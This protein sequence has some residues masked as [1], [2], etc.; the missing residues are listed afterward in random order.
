VIIIDEVLSRLRG[1]RSMGGYWMAC[2][3][4]HPDSKASLSIRASDNGK[5]LFKCFA[6]CPFDAINA[7]LGGPLFT[8]AIAGQVAPPPDA[9]NR[10][11]FAQRLW[12]ASTPANGTIVENY[13]RSRCIKIL[14]PSL[15][16]NSCMKHPVGIFAPG[17]VA[18]V[19]GPDGQLTAIHR[20]FLKDDG[21]GKA[22]LD[23]PKMALGPIRGGAVRLAAAGSRLAVAEGLETALSVQQATGLA[24]WA[25]LGTSNLVRLALPAFVREVFI[26]ADADSAGERAAQAAAHRLMREGRTVHI[27][28]P[29][30]SNDFNDRLR[31]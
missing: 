12:R 11:E 28:R 16:F 17:M 24:S 25:T 29:K 26:S 18:I 9:K 14:P 5:P 31:S 4:S 3:P 7:A 22:E 10:T 21:S 6:G 23:P 1:V 2:C 19:Q 8:R 15:R 30:G 13:L 20:T 27:I